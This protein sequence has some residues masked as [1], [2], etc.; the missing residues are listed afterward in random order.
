MRTT[1][2]EINNADAIVITN[3]GVVVGYVKIRKYESNYD[4]DFVGQAVNI[5]AYPN[6][7]INGFASSCAITTRDANEIA[8]SVNFVKAMSEV[9]A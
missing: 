2:V 3:N 9:N 7:T 1:E 4:V 5:N 8:S 6:I